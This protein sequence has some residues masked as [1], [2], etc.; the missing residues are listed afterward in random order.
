MT[1]FVQMLV[2]T[3]PYVFLLLAYFVWQ[4]VLSLRPRQRPVW[5]MLIVPT[6]F[7]ATGLLRLLLRPSGGIL[8]LTAWLGGGGGLRPT[9]PRDRAS[10]SGG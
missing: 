3:P 8:P 9:G 1:F 10:H 4:G 7:T 6:A 5:R 2:H